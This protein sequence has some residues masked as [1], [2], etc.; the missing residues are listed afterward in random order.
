MV[1]R[2]CGRCGAPNPGGAPYCGKCG[3]PLAAWM[4]AGVAVAA[5]VAPYPQYRYSYAPGPPARSHVGP[6]A[7]AAVLGGV[8]GFAVLVFSLV[9]V[10][11]IRGAFFPC[12]ASCGPLRVTP[13]PEASSFTSRAYGYK[14]GYP[15]SW[16]VEQKDDTAVVL[17]T[18]LHGSFVVRG[19]K[20]GKSDDQLVQQAIADL[21]SSQWQNIQEV[22]PLHGAHIGV[23]NGV[24][25]IYSAQ[26]APSGGQAENVRIAV[27]AANRGGL[28]VVALGVDPADVKGSPNGIPEANSFDYVLAEFTW[29]G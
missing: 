22:G 29:P 17:S 15:S 25:R 2:F 7:W 26:V 1:A 5:P 20:N 16:S 13:F 9:A 4:P 23:Q 18:K 21:P 14:V 8:I 27:V 3:A 6:L 19:T 24:G 10:L 12:T 28:S 11:A